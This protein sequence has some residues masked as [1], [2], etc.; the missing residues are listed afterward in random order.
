[1]ETVSWDDVQRFLRRINERIPGLGLVLPTEAQWEYACRAG[2]ETALYSGDLAIRGERDAPAL[3]PIAWYG[4]N[5]GVDFELD[6]GEDSSSWPDK[7]HPHERAGT[8]PV[9]LK[10]ANPWGL[11]D[12]LGNVWE[13]TQDHWHDNYEGAPDDGSAWEDSDAGAGRVV[14]GGSWG[15]SARHVRAAY[16]GQSRPDGR[17]DALGFRCARVQA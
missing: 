8:H 4:G 3:D 14:R 2:T 1:M 11:Y 10:Q 12:M 15:G 7:Q 5:S 9:G 6:N 16:R 17:Y 13:W